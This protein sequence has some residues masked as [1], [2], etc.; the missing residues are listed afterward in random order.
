[1]INTAAPEATEDGQPASV[2]AVGAGRLN[3][4]AAVAATTTVAPA[5]LSFGAIREGALP[6]NRR[7]TVT[8]TGTATA[9][10]TLTLEPRATDP[11]ARVVLERDSVMLGGG[12]SAAV[13]VSLEGMR[14]LPGVYEGI[15]MVRGGVAP[16]RVPWLYVVGNG[17]PHNIFP[18]YGFGFRGTVSEP[19]PHGGMAFRVVDRQGVSV[20]GV[21]VTFRMTRGGGRVELADTVTDAWGIAGAD[22][23]LGPFAGPQQFVATAGPLSV[24]FDGS[25][26]PKPVIAAGGVVNAASFEAGRAVAPGSWVS[27]FGAGLSDVTRAA[28]AAP[29]PIAMAGANVSFDAPG[30]SV[31]GPLWF[32][33][34]GQVNVQVP[35]ELAGAASARV[36]VNIHAST[37]RLAEVRLAT[38]SPGV[39]E[40]PGP[41]GTRFAAA[42]D[43]RNELVGPHNPARRGEVVQVFVNGLGPVDRQPASGE[44]AP[45]EPLARTL[46]TPVVMI[47]GRPAAVGFSG[48]APGHVGLY[49][50][51]VVT[52]G[53]A[54]SG[55]QP[56]VVSVGGV[57]SP[58][59][60]LPVE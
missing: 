35:W 55:T 1:V 34:A 50:L 53:D 17:E 28:A 45:A 6:V 12:E 9:I 7:L 20:A 25:A 42:L 18:L 56:L 2:L 15:L 51:N 3:A 30:V 24:T 27:I 31:P 43:Q 33:S 44:P 54:P 47:G 26:R 59:V 13:N 57:D 46:A 41:G 11:H 37:G 32:V 60:N 22:A 4:A 21:P 38:Y 52:P 19:H 40:Y 5:T 48:L 58:P 10:L 23:I 16:L 39:F 8:N 14:P 36:K 49:Q 29:L